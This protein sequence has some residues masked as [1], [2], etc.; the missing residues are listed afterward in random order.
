MAT[1]KKAGQKKE[2]LEKEALEEI[3]K[4]KVVAKARRMV[5][6]FTQEVFNINQPLLAELD[7]WLDCQLSAGLLRKVS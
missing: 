6:P 5:N 2:A 7:S 4:I 3:T 1:R